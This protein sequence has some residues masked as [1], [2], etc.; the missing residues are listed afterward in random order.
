MA[1]SEKANVLSVRDIHALSRAWAEAA[2]RAK[3]A[4]FDAVELHAAHGYLP[5]QFLSPLT[6]HRNDEY[7]GSPENR[8]Q[9]LDLSVSQIKN[10]YSSVISKYDDIKKATWK[11]KLNVRQ[12][13]SIEYM[14]SRL[15]RIYTE[16]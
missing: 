12:N 4:G 5:E 10:S 9:F 11:Y 6:N 16:K 15:L 14:C 13:Y 7:G 2:L 3:N 8:R 1:G